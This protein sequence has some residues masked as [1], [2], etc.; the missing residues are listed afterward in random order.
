M[1]IG[2][3]VSTSLMA[4]LALVAVA[5]AKPPSTRPWSWSYVFGFVVNE[6]PFFAAYWLVW[7]TVQA[8]LQ[9]DLT[10][11]VGLAGLTV[12]IVAL[13]LLAVIARRGLAA[14]AQ[15]TAQLADQVGP[16]MAVPQR[17]PWLRILLAPWSFAGRSVHHHRNL[18]YGPAGRRNRLD[19][20]HDDATRNAPVLLHFHG[21]AFRWGRKN[22]EARL[23]LHRLAR[24][25]WVCMTAN[26]RLAPEAS[27]PDAHVDAKRAIA[28][29]R[30]RAADFGGDP[31]RIWV[32]G[33][34]AGG[35]LATM[36]ALTPNDARFQPG[37]TDADTSVSGAI[38][39]Y[40]FY[41]AA[42][43]GSPMPSSP[44]D[45]IHQDA[46]PMFLVHG[47]H[48]TLVL[49][50]DA[51]EFT[52]ALG[53]VTDQPLVYI[54]LPHAQHGFDLFRSARFE[55]VVDAIEAFL[56]RPDVDATR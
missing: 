40:A 11:P 25:G 41:G 49:A 52:T 45:V 54:E 22:R 23:L 44:L 16:T 7:W 24:D 46:P 31:D 9:D 39:L 51:R 50:D 33:S 53:S 20:L 28:W 5:P 42:A 4:A 17:Q 36:S 37:F 56:R 34:S 10:T 27:F 29:A 8:A 18:S 48:D 55:A 26:Y 15:I 1:P 30:R 13:A 43:A 21:G 35:H 38:G 2:Y 6:M 14:R 3:L 47:G 19:V 32:A 12:A